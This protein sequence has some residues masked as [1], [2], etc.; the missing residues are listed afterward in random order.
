MLLVTD[1]DSQTNKRKTDRHTCSIMN[2]VILDGLFRCEVNKIT[3]PIIIHMCH[4]W[5]LFN[6]ISLC[7]N[8]RKPN[9]IL[10]NST[11][12]LTYG[13]VDFPKQDLICKR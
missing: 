4:L 8:N 6:C 10:I 5:C 12:S 7:D 2:D 3:K 11:K 1:G 9:Q 13:A